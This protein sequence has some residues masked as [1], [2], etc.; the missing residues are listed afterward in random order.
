M[1]Y[2]RIGNVAFL[3]HGRWVHLTMVEDP[4]HAA[5]STDDIHAAICLLL[6]W[7]AALTFEK[8]HA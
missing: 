3:L 6:H 1:E 2:A 7:E 5:W 8:E 4:A